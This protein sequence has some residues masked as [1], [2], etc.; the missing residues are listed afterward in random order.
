[1]KRVP[2]LMYHAISGTANR[3]RYVLTESQF[4]DQLDR[5][6]DRGA[7]GISLAQARHP[8]ENRGDTVVL[9]FDDGNRSDVETALPLLESYGFCATFFITTGRVG[10]GREWIDWDGIRTLIEA[11]MDV[12]VHGHTHV[13]MRGLDPT[14]LDRELRLPVRLMRERLGH[15]V[16]TLSFPG[17][18]HDAGAVRYARSL[19]YRALCTSEPGPCSARALSRDGALLPRYTM[20]QQLDLPTFDRI[21]DSH[22]LLVA[23]SRG[24]YRAARL[25][26]GTLGDRLYHRVWSRL[27]GREA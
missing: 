14:G 27:F 9:T 21:L 23:R 4:R 1:M 11:G 2:I 26:K 6:R 15:G 5:I 12:Q 10:T 25:A 7:R 18:R 3:Q 19:G 20:H 16:S 17:G 24:R 8:G 22:P 13:F